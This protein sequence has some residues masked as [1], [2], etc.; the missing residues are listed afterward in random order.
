MNKKTEYEKL[1]EKYQKDLL[2]Y[3]ERINKETVHATE[4]LVNSP[5]PVV[6]SIVAAKPGIPLISSAMVIASGFTS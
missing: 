4:D 3:V 1:T 6:S 2:K 5:S